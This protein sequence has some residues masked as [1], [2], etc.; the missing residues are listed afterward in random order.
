MFGVNEFFFSLTGILALIA[1]V[2][3]SIKRIY[4]DAE[5]VKIEKKRLLPFLNSTKAIPLKAI[6]K[7][8]FEEGHFDRNTVLVE[9]GRAINA[10]RTGLSY[11]NFYF[12]DKPIFRFKAIGTKNEM[13]DFVVVINQ[14]KK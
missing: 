8:E 1:L 14:M 6:R 9:I 11:L 5:Y 2:T 10:V 7:V 4:V 13:K 12:D 3:I